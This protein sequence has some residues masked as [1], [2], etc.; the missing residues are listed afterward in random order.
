MLVNY[1]GSVEC[2]GTIIS[3]LRRLR[4]DLVSDT[5]RKRNIEL[6]NTELNVIEI[7]VGKKK[8]LDKTKHVCHIQN[9]AP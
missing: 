5:S 3:A 4:Q 8:Y 9:C 2:S 6:E 7:I 1:S